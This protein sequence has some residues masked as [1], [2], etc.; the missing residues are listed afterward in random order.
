MTL[1][2]SRKEAFI[3]RVTKHD[4]NSFP[5]TVHLLLFDRM[6][7]KRGR[8]GILVCRKIDDESKLLKRLQDT[9]AKTSA[10]GMRK[11]T[12][13]P[14]TPKKPGALLNGCSGV[15]HG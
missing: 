13:S 2:Q 1:Y 12:A 15:N 10:K 4:V 9:Q 14:T 7:R 5:P 8:F 11:L 3:R 6:G